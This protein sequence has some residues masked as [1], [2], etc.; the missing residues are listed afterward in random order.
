MAHI[1]KDVQSVTKLVEN[2]HSRIVSLQDSTLTS[3]QREQSTARLQQTLSDEGITYNLPHWDSGGRWN[4][5]FRSLYIRDYGVVTDVSP[6]GP[7]PIQLSVG[8]NVSVVFEP[9]D[10]S[11]VDRWHYSD[12]DN[13]RFASLSKGSSLDFGGRLICC[14]YYPDSPGGLF[15]LRVDSEIRSSMSVAIADWLRKEIWGGRPS[16]VDFKKR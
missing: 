11:R 14:D 9:R 1:T 7:Y 2:C 4:F 6:T 12:I 16:G 3:L 5:G 13:T 10:I 15:S 8:E